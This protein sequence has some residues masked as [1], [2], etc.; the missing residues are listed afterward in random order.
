[1]NDI[2]DTVP[3]NAT[4]TSTLKIHSLLT[5]QNISQDSLSL[6][7]RL[8]IAIGRSILSLLSEVLATIQSSGALS[9]AMLAK[10]TNLLQSL[11]SFLMD[12]INIAEAIKQVQQQIL[13][14][15][16]IPPQNEN[17]P[18]AQVQKEMELAILAAVQRQKQ[19]LEAREKERQE[20][21]AREKAEKERQEREAR[22]KAERERQER[23][24]REQ[25]EIKQRATF[26]ND[27]YRESSPAISEAA[28]KEKGGLLEIAI[29]DYSLALQSKD[30]EA[31]EKARGKLE[32][33]YHAAY[34][35]RPIETLDQALKTAGIKLIASRSST[36]PSL[37]SEETP[38]NEYEDVK[39]VYQALSSRGK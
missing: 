32:Q 1:M 16:Q 14:I 28:L 8:E 3:E 15:L 17:R 26:R 37:N 5:Q 13:E 39:K 25:A 34:P 6:K 19:E 23:E 33:V 11:P 21:E 22:E 12:N 10:A 31:M 29:D 36:S 9:S 4:S 30:P 27:F 35:L 24:A 38:T 20:R 2:V 7:K 18:A